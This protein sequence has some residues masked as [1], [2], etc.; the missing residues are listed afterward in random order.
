MHFGEWRVRDPA[1]T[2]A[3]HRLQRK[4]RSRLDPAVTLFDYQLRVR[5]DTNPLLSPYAT[6]MTAPA[7]S[8]HGLTLAGRR[9]MDCEVSRRRNRRS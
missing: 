4:S 3:R 6:A 8:M 1:K 9:S 7:I 5:L 2:N